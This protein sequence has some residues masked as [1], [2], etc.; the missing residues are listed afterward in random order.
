MTFRAIKRGRW[1]SYE[2]DGQKVPSVTKL[3]GDGMPKPNLID[4]AARAAAE[5]AADHIDEIGRLERDA[6]VD[7]I[8]TAHNRIKSGGATKGGSIHDYAEQ[9]A[10]GAKVDV[11]EAM[12]GYVDAYLAY[13][14]DWS[15]QTVALEAP[16]GNHRWRYGGRLDALQRLAGRPLPAVID[17]KTGGSGVWPETCLQVAAYRHADTIILD[18]L[19]QPMP[20]TEGGYALWLGDDGNYEL[21]PVASGDDVFAVFLHVAHVA[22]FMGREKDDLI[23]LPLEAPA[24]V[25]S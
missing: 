2:I 24:A 20:E 23:G 3:I 14:R 13:T 6:A 1:Y 17:T 9:L 10:G 11:P 19:P 21:L 22:G 16:V 5:Y 25:A 15:P 18:G 8:K 4:W 7:L 12:A